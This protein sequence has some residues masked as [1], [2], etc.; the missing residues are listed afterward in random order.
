VSSELRRIIPQVDEVLR[1]SEFVALGLSHGRVS[2]TLAVRQAID[3]LRN[4][5]LAQNEPVPPPE[6]V[7]EALLSRVTAILGA[8]LQASLRRVINCTGIPLHTNLGRAPLAASAIEAVVQAA[9]GYST[10]EY[11]VDTGERGSRQSHVRALLV[12][13]TKAESALVVNNNAGAVLL[14]LSALANQR[15]VVVSRGEL[16]E[17]GGNFRIPEVMEQGGAEL[18]EVGTTN[19]TY[20]ADYERAITART[21]ALLKVHTSN[22][23]VVGFAAAASREQVVEVAHR[24]GIL[25]IEDLGSGAL[26]PLHG[27]PTVAEAVAAGMDIVTFS[28][29][30][31]LGGPQAGII[32]GKKECIARL[33]KHPLARALRIDKLT[34]A[35]LLATLRLYRQGAQDEQVPLLA[36]LTKDPIRYQ[37]EAEQ[38][39][40]AINAL[41]ASLPAWRA[42]VKPAHAQVGGG[43]LPGKEFAGFVVAIESPIGCVALEQR[44]RCRDIPIVARIE[45]DR[46]LIDPR[47]LLAGDRE[48]VIA[49]LEAIAAEGAL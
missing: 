30:K 37:S 7:H 12:E 10:L 5:I 28:G 34:L 11:D 20:A 2:V 24:Y 48:E 21:A 14:A 40:A 9:T 45:K 33:E 23:Q 39:A 47:C 16:V 8:R 46:V 13:L 19:K 29:D 27:E 26:V 49:A 6:G 1:R 15:E 4:T 18:R 44:L 3:E 22:Y 17:V 41:P 42:E 25:A 31:L 32:V 43:S 36:M 35:A 38:L